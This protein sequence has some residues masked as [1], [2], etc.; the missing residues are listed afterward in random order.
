MENQ[1]SELNEKEIAK[2]IYNKINQYWGKFPNIWKYTTKDEIASEVAIDLYRPRKADGVPHIMHYF[3]TKGNR[4]ISALVGTLVYN[5]LMASARI[6]YSTSVYDNE[7]R[8]N[9]ANAVSLNATLPNVDDEL[10]LMDVVVDE[11][12]KVEENAE[13]NWVL[14]NLPNKVIDSVF[15]FKDDRYISVDYRLLLELVMCGYSIT[16]ISERLYCKNKKGDLVYYKGTSN[17]IRLMKSDMKEYLKCE[18]GFTEDKYREGWS[19]L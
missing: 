10:T 17:L 15:Y 18:Y 5:N 11:K 16:Q 4:S 1:I 2:E 12:Q 14:N 9:V 6:I 19:I 8:R 7:D 3:K 13:Y